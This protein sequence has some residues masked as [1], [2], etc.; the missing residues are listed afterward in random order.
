MALWVNVGFGSIISASRIVGVVGSESAPLKRKIQEARE[1]GLLIDATFGRKTRTVIFMASG[2]IVASAVA[3][4]TIANRL[5][6]KELL[7]P[8]DDFVEE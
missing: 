3:V 1:D 8:A 7:N 6:A 4:E 2:H 5:E